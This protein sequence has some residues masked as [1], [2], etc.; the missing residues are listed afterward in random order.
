MANFKWTIHEVEWEKELGELNNVIDIIHWGYTIE[1]ENGN[2]VKDIGVERLEHNPE[3]VFIPYEEV[4]P[5]MV[6]EWLEASIGED[7][8]AEMQS[9][10]E[11]RLAQK[12]N[13]PRGRGFY[14]KE[15]PIK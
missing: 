14:K 1:D 13:P 12:I 5:E 7:R 3:D 4:T 8:I 11:A 9:Q 10:L 15:E 2:I 6:I